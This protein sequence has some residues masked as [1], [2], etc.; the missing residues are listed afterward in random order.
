[1][2]TDIRTHPNGTSS[3]ADFQAFVQAVQAALTAVGWTKTTDTGQINSATVANPAAGVVGGYEV[4]AMSDT[5]QA[6]KPVLLRLDYAASSGTAAGHGLNVTIGL[7]GSDGAGNLLAPKSATLDARP[8][9]NVASSTYSLRTSGASNR[10]ALFGGCGLAFVAGSPF[11]F[12]VERSHAD[13]GTDSTDGAFLVT[14]NSYAPAYGGG[15]SLPGWS[16][17]YVPFTGAVPPAQPTTNYGAGYLPMPWYDAGT[18]VVG[19]SVGVVPL[20]MPSAGVKDPS[21]NLAGYQVADLANDFT[22]TV[23]QYGAN[24]TYRTMGSWLNCMGNAGAIVSSTTRD[25]PSRAAMMRWE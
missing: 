5:L 6:T 13:D 2:A 19:L 1:M 10:L 23:P 25:T 22:V 11:G 21:F 18:M 16:C 12:A 4:Y 14:M 17:A 15:G 9:G 24:R 20:Y 7:G 3:N 8:Y